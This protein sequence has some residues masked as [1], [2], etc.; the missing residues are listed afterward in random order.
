MGQT[1]APELESQTIGT[2][3]C[4]HAPWAQKEH[5]AVGSDPA[6]PPAPGRCVVPPM[7]PWPA[8]PGTGPVPPN[9][10]LAPPEPPLT[11]A[12]PLRL[13]LS[14]AT[15]AETT[16]RATISAQASATYRGIS[17]ADAVSRPQ[18]SDGP[19]TEY[20]PSVSRLFSHSG[21]KNPRPLLLDTRASSASPGRVVGVPAG[22]ANRCRRTARRLLLPEPNVSEATGDLGH[23]V[24]N[25]ED[26]RYLLTELR[27]LSVSRH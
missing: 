1:Q 17:S 18:P 27:K 19:P 24:L 2:R 26:E 16:T 7:P 12:E 22:R 25:G 15:P 9:P 8:A 21:V 13:E 20:R 23:L 11:V 14:Q 4:Q 6:Q 3:S 5:F 10:P